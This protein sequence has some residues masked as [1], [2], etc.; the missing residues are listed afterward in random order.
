MIATEIYRHPLCQVGIVMILAV[1]STFLTDWFMIRSLWNGIWI[2]AAPAFVG[3]VA[4]TGTA[5]QL[6]MTFLLMAV[7]AI[8]LMATAAYFGL[9][10]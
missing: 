5:R 6:V 4:N 8:S 9:G 2:F 10:Y 3:I 7:S 1:I